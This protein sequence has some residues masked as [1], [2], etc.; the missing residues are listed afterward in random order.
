[1][2]L[3]QRLQRRGGAPRHS[4]RRAWPTSAVHALSAAFG[5]DAPGAERTGSDLGL[6]R[7]TASKIAPPPKTLITPALFSRP[8][9][10]PLTGRRG[11]PARPLQPGPPLPGRGMGWSGAWGGRAGEGLENRTRLPARP[12][13][14]CAR[15]RRRTGIERRG[16]GR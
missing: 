7:A 3:A 12:P 5:A 1:G 13:P 14:R 15:R 2:A 6:L 11:R 4:R 10:T 9:P 8:L 16:S